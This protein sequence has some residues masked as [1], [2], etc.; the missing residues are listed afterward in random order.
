MSP[1]GEVKKCARCHR[2]RDKAVFYCADGGVYRDICWACRKEAYSH[3]KAL[4][5][6]VTDSESGRKYIKTPEPFEDTTPEV[7]KVEHWRQIVGAS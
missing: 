4:K 7:L 1:K 5:K 6:E 3:A 2:W